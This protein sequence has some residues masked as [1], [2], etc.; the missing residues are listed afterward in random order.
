MTA[1]EMRICDLSSDVL[2][3]D[4]A[5]V[6][7]CP[8]MA[9]PG[10]G[11]LRNRTQRLRGAAIV[12]QPPCPKIGRFAAACRADVRISTMPSQENT[13]RLLP[14]VA[15]HAQPHLAGALDWE[16]GRAS[17]RARVCQYV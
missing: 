6:A 7:G 9:A 2:S 5:G 1:Y 8:C 3:S 15:V 10:A 16:I 13:A 12:R 14:D 4:L 11:A 17:C